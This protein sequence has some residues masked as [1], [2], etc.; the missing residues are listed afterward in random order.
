[1]S[2]QEEPILQ[3]FKFAHL[4]EKLQTVSR[5]FCEMADNI[6]T[7]LPRNSERS[8]ALRKLLEAK[9]AAVRASI[10]VAL[11]L[12]LLPRLAMA[13]SD[14]G[15]DAP[16]QVDAGLSVIVAGPSL[17]LGE[18]LAI[19]TAKTVAA[20]ESE[21]DKLRSDVNSEWP[22][23]APVLIGVVALGA[24]VSVGYGVAKTVK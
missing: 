12:C 9:D 21:R 6:V 15:V 24:G 5:P 3:F 19:S 2:E 22:W 14:G 17:V 18:S 8:V 23:W 20:C 11:I 7:N 10:A 16:F 1:M 13:E 4:P